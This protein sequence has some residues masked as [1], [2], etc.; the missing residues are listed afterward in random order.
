MLATALVIPLIVFVFESLLS[1]RYASHYNIYNFFTFWRD[2][3]IKSGFVGVKPRQR[4]VGVLSAAAQLSLVHGACYG[5]CHPSHRVC[6]GVT[7]LWPVRSLIL[8]RVVII[9]S[10]FWGDAS[11]NSYHLWGWRLHMLYISVWY[12]MLAT[13]LVIPLIMF[14]FESILSGR[15]A[16]HFL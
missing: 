12:M 4:P 9:H 5:P 13:A 14:V 7:P 1:G 6:L 15:C 8:L 11:M 2:T 3:S 10:N 16:S